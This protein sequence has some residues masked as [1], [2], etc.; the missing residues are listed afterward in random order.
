MGFK[1]RVTHAPKDELGELRII[2]TSDLPKIIATTYRDGRPL[3]VTIENMKSIH[4]ETGDYVLIEKLII[5]S[6]EGGEKY[7]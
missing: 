1:I 2:L 4:D 3:E 7:E 5:Q 6:S